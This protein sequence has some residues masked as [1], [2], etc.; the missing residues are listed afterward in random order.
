FCWAIG[1]F[2]LR[3]RRP[4]ADHLITASYHMILGGGTMTLLGLLMGEAS[5]LT[6]G[7]FT[8]SAVASFFYLLVGG[9]LLGCLAYAWLLRHVSTTLVG[10]HAYVN[11][12]IALV[13]GAI[14]NGETITANIVAGMLIIF[15]GVA[16]VRTGSRTMDRAAVVS[17]PVTASTAPLPTSE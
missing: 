1:S 5:Q 16:L 13:V 7:S 12:M 17:A 11:P 2:T 9:S 4:K 15:A 10:T 6:P 3:H 14:L 8:A